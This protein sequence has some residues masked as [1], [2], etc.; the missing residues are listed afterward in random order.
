[1]IGAKG[2][3][4]RLRGIVYGVDRVDRNG[5]GGFMIISFREISAAR[6]TV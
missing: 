3:K 5:G 4:I 2:I 6:F 1:M